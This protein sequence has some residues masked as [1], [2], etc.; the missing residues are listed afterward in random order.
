M[1]KIGGA[2]LRDGGGSGLDHVRWG[3]LGIPSDHRLARLIQIVETRHGTLRHAVYQK[4]AYVA[5]HKH[6][7]AALVYGALA[8]LASNCTSAR[9]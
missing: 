1:S 8:A 4:G 7:V 3:T 6:D 2:V 9:R 5:S